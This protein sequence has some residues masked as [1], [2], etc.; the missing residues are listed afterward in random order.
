MDSASVK[1]FHKRLLPLQQRIYRSLEDEADRLLGQMPPA[2][3]RYERQYR[4]D[5]KKFLRSAKI[6]EKDELI[7]AI[8]HSEVTLIADFHTFPQAQRTAL[9]LMREAITPQ[10]HEKYRWAIGLELVPSHYQKFLDQFQE[11]KLS[12]QEFH[13]A[14][15]YQEEWGFPWQNYQ[16]IFDWARENGVRILGLN[17]PKEIFRTS[18]TLRKAHRDSELQARDR[19][20]AGI[21]SDWVEHE[22]GKVIV[23]YGELHVA[24]RHLPYW[25]SQVSKEYIGKPIKLVTVH[26]NNDELYWR[27]ALKGRGGAQASVLS[28]RKNIYCVLSSTPWAKLQSLINWA[29]GS[30]LEDDPDYLGEL[31]TYGQTIASLLGVRVPAYELLNVRTINEADFVESVEGMHGFS[32]RELQIIRHQV[33]TNQ[34]FYVPRVNVAYVGSPSPNGMAEL[35]ALYLF[36]VHS[37]SQSILSD[38]E[39]LLDEF[40]RILL[41][42]AFGFFGSLFINPK[43]KCDLPADHRKK[44]LE[45]RKQL[46]SRAPA[47]MKAQLATQLEARELSLEV[48]KWRK[49]RGNEK[50]AAAELRSYGRALKLSAPTI[51]LAAKYV[52]QILAKRLYE[53]LAAEKVSPERISELFFKQLAS[54][55]ISYADRYFQ[56]LNETKTLKL[57][58]S[59]AEEL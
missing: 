41:E 44:I 42:S 35:A 29:E 28:L 21:I 52:G 2:I 47:S 9:R 14:I 27:F 56:I 26:Q 48:L 10:E 16:P 45:I 23:L 24:G 22:K 17:Q 53:V 37:G 32:K 30:E 5:F 54:S 6:A 51:A 39:E 36:R 20:A 8:Q 31:N 12:L 43:R 19:W 13:E 57:A 4:G 46:R 50:A 38:R 34:R 58:D 7:H 33:A 1:G 18:A 55:K 25:I 3:Q 40:F 15:H 11:G 59:K 49:P